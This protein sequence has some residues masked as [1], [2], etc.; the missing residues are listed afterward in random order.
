MLVTV[1][2]YLGSIPHNLSPSVCVLLT[3]LVTIKLSIVSILL[4]ISFCVLLQ[5]IQYSMDVPGSQPLNSLHLIHFQSCEIS[6]FPLLALWGN[7]NWPPS[8][9]VKNVENLETKVA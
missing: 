1:K 6:V 4:F 3:M 2:L 9:K 8:I 7:K 5:M